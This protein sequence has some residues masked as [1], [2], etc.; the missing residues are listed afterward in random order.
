M[1]LLVFLIDYAQ[2]PDQD[3]SGDADTSPPQTSQRAPCHG[4]T[5]GLRAQPLATL[6]ERK[7][8]IGIIF[9]ELNRKGEL[10][11]TVQ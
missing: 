2:E 7:S 4:P 5:N 8:V 6:P 10:N 9:H 3:W 11:D 1:E